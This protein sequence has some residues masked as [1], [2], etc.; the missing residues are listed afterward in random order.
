MWCPQGMKE[1]EIIVS[2]LAG[3]ADRIVALPR[4]AKLLHRCDWSLFHKQQLSS[5]SLILRTRLISDCQ[6]NV[7][8]PLLAQPACCIALRSLRAQR[9]IV[10]RSLIGSS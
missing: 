10:Q 5:K 1:K 2:E 9:T 8:A 6:A 7:I 3:A 4:G